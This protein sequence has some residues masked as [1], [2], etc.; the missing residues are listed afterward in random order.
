MALD[1]RQEWLSMLFRMNISDVRAPC[2]QV[3]GFDSA[4]D[5]L[6]VTQPT[7]ELPAASWEGLRSCLEVKAPDLMLH[8][9]NSYS[10][11][12]WQRLILHHCGLFGATDCSTHLC[13]VT[14]L[15]G[16]GA[17]VHP[18]AVMP[19]LVV[20]QADMQCQPGSPPW[21]EPLLLTYISSPLAAG[22]FTC[23]HMPG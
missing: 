3:Q 10:L 11:T 2:T 4:A 5:R 6:T 13:S 22:E 18:L 14:A 19:S 21:T 16:T 9:Q 17:A 1:R 20:S 12:V 8:L 7:Q 15:N 23:S